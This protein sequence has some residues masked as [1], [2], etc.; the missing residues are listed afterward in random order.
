M[1]DV[2]A[3]YVADYENKDPA[4]L[5]VS[6]ALEKGKHFIPKQDSDKAFTEV[7]SLEDNFLEVVGFASK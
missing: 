3:R 2:I 4:L 6:L 7:K 5:Y 1:A